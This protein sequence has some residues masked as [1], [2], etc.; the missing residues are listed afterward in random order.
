MGILFHDLEKFKDYRPVILL[1]VSRF[2]FSL[3]SSHD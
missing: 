2:G 3:M 1:N